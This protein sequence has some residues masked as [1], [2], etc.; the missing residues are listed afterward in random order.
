LRPV[1]R[2]TRKSFVV[3]AKK[4]GYDAI[5]VPIRLRKKRHME[6]DAADSENYKR[7]RW[8]LDTDGQR[9]LGAD[10]DHW[11]EAARDVEHAGAYESSIPEVP[12]H[13]VNAHGVEGEYFQ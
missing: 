6:A 11:M 8:F 4:Y 13:E 12:T 1:R 9:I 2:T 5:Q 3:D 7:T 10:R